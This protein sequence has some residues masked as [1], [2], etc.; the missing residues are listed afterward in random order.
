[1]RFRQRVC[2]N[3]EVVINRFDDSGSFN[4][5]SAVQRASP[6]TN[7]RLR[8]FGYHRLEK[9]SRYIQTGKSPVFCLTL[10][11]QLIDIHSISS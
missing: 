9:C 8:Q 6:Q 1:M 11:F 7:S 10:H 3:D 2:W 4:V 5:K